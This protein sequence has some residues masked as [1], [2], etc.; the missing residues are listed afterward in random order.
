MKCP[1][2]HI[3]MLV[4]EYNSIELDYCDNCHGVWF[5]SGELELFAGKLGIGST[6]VLNPLCHN[7]EEKTRKCPICG[8]KM[9][10]CSV[11]KSVETILDSCPQGD[12]LWFDGGE[13]AHLAKQAAAHAGKPEPALAFLGDVFQASK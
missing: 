1:V 5:D 9:D 4:V 12:G 3:D 13:V 10:K 6:G 2:C 11:A 8:K 7:T